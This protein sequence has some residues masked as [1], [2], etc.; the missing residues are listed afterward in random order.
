MIFSLDVRRAGKGDCL[1]LHFGTKAKPGLMLIDGGFKQVW[2]PHLKPRLLQIRKARGLA[3][4]EP[5]PVDVMMLSHVDADHIQGLLELTEEEIEALDS[6]AGNLLLSVAS[7]WHNSFSALIGQKPVTVEAAFGTASTARALP[8]DRDIDRIAADF[9]GDRD[10]AEDMAKVFASIPQGNQLRVDARKLGYPI[11]AEFDGKLI[12]ARRGGKKITFPGGLKVTVAGPMQKELERLQQEHVKWLKEMKKK[13]KKVEQALAA[14]EDDSIPNLSSLV[15]LLEA[16]GKTIL[17]TGDA[18]GDKILQGLEL[19]GLLKP[20][21]Q[22]EVDILK[23]PHHGSVHNVDADFFKRVV[24][25]HYVFSG[26]GVHGNP[27]RETLEMLLTARGVDADYQV[28]LTY[29]LDEIDDT[30]KKER[31]QK[32]KPWNAANHSL[33]DLFDAKPKF[34]AKLRIAPAGKAHVIDL[35]D[36][37]G[38]AW[39]ALG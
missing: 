16:D 5:L 25:R 12:M 29:P 11:N 1:L 3:D 28:H 26:D 8:S 30:H 37:L 10:T 9:G 4:D 21:K 6:P 14:Y 17:L 19:V 18:R 27:D 35:A 2:K 38:K 36:P 31:K 20:G 33:Q 24:A 15:L 22:I 23:A 39:P 32:K 7:L 13:G 34:K